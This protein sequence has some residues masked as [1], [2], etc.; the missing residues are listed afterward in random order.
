MFLKNDLYFVKGLLSED[1]EWSARVMIASRQIAVCHVSIYKRIRRGNGSITSQ[2]GERNIRDILASLEKG[3]PYAEIHAESPHLLMLYYE[4]WSY[5]YAMLLCLLSIVKDSQEYLAFIERMKKLSWLLK[6]HHVP[7]VRLVNIAYRILGI[8]KLCCCWAD[9]IIADCASETESKG[10]MKKILSIA[11]KLNIGGAEKVAA[12]IGLRADPQKYIVHYVVFGDEIGAYEPELEACGCKIFHLPSPSDS[13][14]AYLSGLKRLIHTYHYDAIHAH[15][16]F[17]IGWVMFAG[18]LYGVPVRVAHAHS[19]LEEHRS[20]KARLYESAMRF[21]ILTC[22]TD[23]IA[24]GVK[25]GHRLY[26]RK[27][28]EKKGTLILN[29]IDTQGFAFDEQ[30]RNAFRKRA[31][32]G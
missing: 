20:L 10:R 21:L 1:I 3:I 24:C 32:L 15:T 5:Q 19:A 9:T 27:A 25:A 13:Y 14:R 11:A 29:G 26:G 28:F 31:W 4:Y 30:R 8:K 23:Y 7:K 17:N 12:D 16:M 22:A 6:F 2:I 18:K